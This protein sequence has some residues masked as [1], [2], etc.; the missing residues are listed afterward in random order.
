VITTLSPRPDSGTRASFEASATSERIL[1]LRR[2]SIGQASTPISRQQEVFSSCSTRSGPQFQPA[3]TMSNENTSDPPLPTPKGR[4]VSEALLNEKVRATYQRGDGCE[5]GMRPGPMRA[6]RRSERRVVPMGHVRNCHKSISLTGRQQWDRFLSSTVIKS[7][8]GLSFGVIFSVLL[9]K[10]RAWPVFF[11]AGFGAGRAWEEADG[12]FC[13]TGRLAQTANIKQ[14]IS[15]VVIDHSIQTACGKYGRRGEQRQAC[16]VL[17]G[18]FAYYRP[19]QASTVMR[20]ESKLG[21][22]RH[23]KRCRAQCLLQ[24]RL[25]TFRGLHI[26]TQNSTIYRPAFSV[27][28]SRFRLS[29][30]ASLF[31]RWASRPSTCSATRARS[32]LNRL[33]SPPALAALSE[34][35]STYCRCL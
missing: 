31:R 14:Q 13:T 32:S 2:S 3:A 30:S 7:G 5:L 15:S 22:E 9:F 17:A 20:S 11:G 16:H 4:P 21:M 8:L 24:P 25:T 28:T 35:N 10:R 1:I 33:R 12:G 18:I 26:C 6:S 27:S 34:F 23:G 29:S 19:Q